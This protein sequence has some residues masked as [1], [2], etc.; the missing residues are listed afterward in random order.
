MVI[1]MKN[2]YDAIIERESL[3]DKK[4]ADAEITKKTAEMMSKL[5]ID[6]MMDRISTEIKKAVESE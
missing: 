1:M 6:S 5:D 4:V 3:K 2:L